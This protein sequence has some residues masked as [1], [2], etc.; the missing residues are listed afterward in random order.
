MTPPKDF[1]EKEKSV[2]LNHQTENAS[3]TE[4]SEVTDQLDNLNHTLEAGLAIRICKCK[5]TKLSSFICLNN[6]DIN[7][8]MVPS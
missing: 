6:L 3:S 7:R 2:K 4:N 5:L 1:E 8:K